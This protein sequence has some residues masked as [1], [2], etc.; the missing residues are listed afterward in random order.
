M[1][2]MHIIFTVLLIGH[3]IAQEIDFRIDRP[4]KVVFEQPEKAFMKPRWSPDGT[5]IAF[6]GLKHIGLY[7]INSDGS[8]YRQLS[9]EPG[10][11]YNYY[12][13]PDSRMISTTVNTYIDYRQ[14]EILKVF[15]IYSGSVQELVSPGEQPKISLAGFIG[16]NKLIAGQAERIELIN[17]PGKDQSG[18]VTLAGADQ[19]LC[20]SIGTDIALY[21][22]LT[23][24]YAL[25]DPKPGA[26]YLTP[27]LSP[28][29]RFIAFRIYG[30]QMYI[31]DI[32][33]SRAV[34][35][36]D[37]HHP[38]WANNS[39]WIVFER[40]SDDG[41]SIITADLFIAD[42]TGQRVGQ[43]TNTADELEVNPDW[44]PVSNQIVYEN[45]STGAIHVIE[46]ADIR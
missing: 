7:M 35:L 22:L 6:T 4:V 41:H 44:S 38:R 36:G 13:S 28:D 12:W 17:V 5:K 32:D 3:I 29:Y 24:N 33:S 30:D 9:D 10:A 1:F 37:G 43:L 16:N 18:G 40:S 45:L 34:P 19:K 42:K 21:E 8:G 15:D 11:G 2:K 14:K 25:I 46:L 26:H 20:L 31:Y 39:E 27:V 23:G